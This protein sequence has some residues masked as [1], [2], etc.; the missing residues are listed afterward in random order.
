MIDFLLQAT[1]SNLL[2]ASGMA[3]I[4]WQV[5]NRVP[6]SSLSNLLWA[7]VLVKLITPPV[8][9][10][11]VL[12]VPSLTN[13]NRQA[14][15]YKAALS[16]TA[17]VIAA[18]DL[19]SADTLVN[20]EH[21]ASIAALPWSTTFAPAMLLVWVLGSITLLL[22][23]AYRVL[24]FHLLLRANSK[25]A[26]PQLTS[27]ADQVSRRIRLKSRPSLLITSANIAPFVWWRQGRAAIVVSKVT[28][29]QLSQPDLEN[30]FAHEMAHIKRRDHWMRWL[31]W[32]CLIALWWNPL[33]WLARRQLRLS[34]EMACDEL[35]ISSSQTC[36]QNYA[37]SLLNM[38]EL[39]A[40]STTRPPVVASAINSGG[41]L[42]KRLKAMMNQSW[43][44]PATLKLAILGLAFFLFPMGLVVAQDFGAIEKRLGGAVEAGEITLE[45]AFVMMEA[46]RD[47]VTHERHDGMREI[48]ERF[49]RDMEKIQA[50]V[51]AGKLSEED[52][53]RKI[54]VMKA[55]IAKRSEELHKETS[56]RDLRLDQSLIK[57]NLEHEKALKLWY[58][59][60][61]EEIKSSLES[62]QLS[63]EE[64]ERKMMEIRKKIEQVRRAA[65]DEKEETE[66]QQRAYL[67]DLFSLR[68][69]A[70]IDH[71]DTS[72]EVARK[73]LLELKRKIAHEDRAAQED[74]IRE[75]MMRRFEFDVQRINSAVDEGDSSEQRAE[76][77]LFEMQHKSLLPHSFKDEPLR[78]KTLRPEIR[79]DDAKA[80][81]QDAALQEAASDIIDARRIPFTF[82]L[83]DAKQRPEDEASNKSPVELRQKEKKSDSGKQVQKP[84][85]EADAQTVHLVPVSIDSQDQQV[86]SFFMG[87]PRQ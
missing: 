73:R 49:R 53:E 64:A 51:K 66:A 25:E 27:L 79:E 20:A 36:M 55:S 1:L 48:K 54:A 30:V 39:L 6:S 21:S 68:L 9:S 82:Y 34:E 3:L 24:R 46:L 13:N 63:E 59:K 74:R 33:M 4:A 18:M 62:G 19:D 8:V 29:Q 31:E 44:V 16:A 83:Q 75:E 65:K 78:E 7:L 87:F 37:N 86:F 72:E 84:A 61:A 12:Q 69:K 58:S 60:Y 40:A 85:L 81:K 57:A 23:S 26:A 56:D 15:R 67:E 80:A 14:D 17:E 10:L 5:Q 32:A 50:A 52:A 35:V 41:Q 38:A 22:I 43:K 2:I 47:S 76:N 70:A 42:E 45:Q 28:T 77:K 71:G 11:P